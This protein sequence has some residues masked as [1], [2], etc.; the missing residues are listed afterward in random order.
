MSLLFLRFQ[1]S[2]FRNSK[3]DALSV[4]VLKKMGDECPSGEDALKYYVQAKE[5]A[6]TNQITTGVPE[7][8]INRVSSTGLL[9]LVRD[10]SV[11]STA[12]L[13]YGQNILFLWTP[14]KQRGKGYATMLLQQVAKAYES[15]PMTTLWITA[16]EKIFP[17]CERAGY[18]HCGVKS[19]DGES[20]DFYPITL[21][22]RYKR[23]EALLHNPSDQGLMALFVIE[24]PGLIQVVK[25]LSEKANSVIMRCRC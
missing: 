14:V 9:F 17:I 16:D 1:P 22:D 21:E 24:N 23:R 3:L 10:G 13:N 12:Y 2:T 5:N 15:V 4:Y 6:N 8:F 20:A 25:N 7:G 19:P 11:L 18:R